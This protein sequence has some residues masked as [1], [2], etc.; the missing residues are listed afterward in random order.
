MRKRRSLVL[1]AVLA[2]SLAAWGCSGGSKGESGGAE[3]GS[4]AQDTQAAAAG[5]TNDTGDTAGFMNVALGADIQTADV[6]KTTKDYQIPINIL[7]AWWMWKLRTTVLPRSCLHWQRAGRS[8]T[9]L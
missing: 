7:T 5:E 2:A 3:T 9:M 4:E 1:A 6:H 8:A